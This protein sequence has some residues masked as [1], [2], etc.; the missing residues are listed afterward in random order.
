MTNNGDDDGP[1]LREEKD[2]KEFYPSLDEDSL[3]PIIFDVSNDSNIKLSIPDNNIDSFQ[4]SNNDSIPCK[5]IILNGKITTEPLI[6]GNSLTNF[7]RS[8]IDIEA[9]VN[10]SG[11]EGP[12]KKSPKSS[13]LITSDSDGYPVK[14]RHNHTKNAF[15]MRD[16]IRDSPGLKN[17]KV[18]YD[19]DEQDYLYINDYLNQK[20]PSLYLNELQFET[21]I[22]VLEY[23]WT[24]MQSHFPIPTP[25]ITSFDQ[26]CSVCNTEETQTNVIIFCD[27]CNI[28]V[29]Q[30]CYGIIFIPPGPWLCRPCIQ[31]NKTVTKPYCCVCPEIGGPL[32]QTSCGTWVHIWCT[33]WIT[34]LSFGNWH[35]LEPVEGIEKIPASR[36]RLVCSICKVKH[37]A[38]IQCSNKNCFTAFHVTCA[39]KIGLQMTLLKTGSLAEMALGGDKL[40]CFC[41]RHSAEAP[42]FLK[43]RIEEVKDEVERLNTF[44]ILDGEVKGRNQSPLDNAILNIR[45]F[46][47]TP[48]IFVQQIQSLM[49]QLVTNKTIIKTASLDICKYWSLKRELN[50]GAPLF[51]PSTDN[52]Y[53]YDLLNPNHLDQ[54]LDFTNVLI[55]HLAPLN[56]LVKLVSERNDISTKKMENNRK[57]NTMI[58]N[59][60]LF[61]LNN[62]ILEKFVN[63]EPY[64]QLTFLLTEP[65]FSEILQKCQERKFESLSDYYMSMNNMFDEILNSADTNRILSRN[66]ERAKE[67]LGDTEEEIGN[68]ILKASLEQDFVIQNSLNIEEA[69]WR[70]SR[71]MRE[72]DLSDVDEL[73]DHE[74]KDLKAILTQEKTKRKTC[75]PKKIR[76]LRKKRG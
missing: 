54:Q 66:I 21:L 76:N 5:Q 29:H 74:I 57:I 73:S 55:D 1:K 36:W 39:M 30:E 53:S 45:K 41:D 20:Y 40:G 11:T 64:K 26:L 7:H 31:K 22:S 68:N 51:E 61:L 14:I 47:K 27:S 56:K 63:S 50:D 32:K 43:E 67:Y 44:E 34:E 72:E 49:S 3:I 35:Y 70:Y 48:M 16:L 23:Q 2:Y 65:R 42:L 38:C 62:I 52:L 69:K 75:S 25:Q 19:M 46:P 24:F 13:R 59:P 58:T 71:E 17:F 28:A 10:D 18:C 15:N 8:N 9:L 6:I 12:D 4:N 60:E 33:I 37:G